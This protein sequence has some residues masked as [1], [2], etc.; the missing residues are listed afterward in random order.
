V[1]LAGV[2]ILQGRWEEAGALLDGRE[3]LPEATIAAADLE[4][5]RGDTALAIARLLRRANLLGRDNLLAA[6]VLSR[7]VEAQ[8]AAGDSD[9][10]SVSAALLVAASRDT[11]HPLLIGHAALAT[12]HVEIAR[13]EPATEHLAVAVDRFTKLELLLDAAKARLEL[14]REVAGADPSVALDHATK[15][16]AAFEEHGATHLADQA[17]ALVRDLGGPARTGPKDVGLLTRR[18]A[19]VLRL[20]GEGLSNAEVGARLFISTKTAGHHVSNILAKL[21]LRSRQEA[22]AYAVRTLRPEPEQI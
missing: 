8:L 19:E 15:A 21:Q 10:A 11:G 9:G 22:A 7:L 14:A 6:P 4:L 16:Y 1:K 20:L 12:G 17:A 2:R 18:E 13:G 3:E 5:A